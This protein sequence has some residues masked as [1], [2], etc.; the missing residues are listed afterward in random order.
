MKLTNIVSVKAKAANGY[1]CVVHLLC[2]L[3]N[4]CPCLFYK[5]NTYYIGRGLRTRTLRKKNSQF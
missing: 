1:V 3:C 2:G 5:L 4:R